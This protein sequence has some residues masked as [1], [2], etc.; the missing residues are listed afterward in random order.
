MPRDDGKILRVVV[1]VIWERLNLDSPVLAEMQ[2]QGLRTATTQ[3]E[4]LGRYGKTAGTIVGGR[5]PCRF[6][7]QSKKSS[8]PEI[9]ERR[10]TR[11]VNTL[12]QHTE[13]IALSLSRVY[14][15]AHSSSVTSTTCDC[16]G[17]PPV[18]IQDAEAREER[19]LQ[20]DRVSDC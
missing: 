5:G 8:F 15:A 2:C 11:R 7:F 6:C 18:N 20:K 4:I 13:P 1:S 10:R 9:S 3:P 16:D 12:R 17:R 14:F 19:T